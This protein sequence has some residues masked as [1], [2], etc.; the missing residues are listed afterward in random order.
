MWLVPAET[1]ATTRAAT[2]YQPLTDAAAEIAAGNYDRA[3]TLAQPAVARRQRAC[4]LRVLLQGH[5]AA[6]P[7]PRRGCARRRSTP[8]RSASRPAI[9]RSRRRSAKPRRPSRSAITPGAGIYEKLTAD[10]TVVNEQILAK[11]AEAA[12]VLGDRRKTAE[13]LLRIYYE[14]PLTDAAVAA[15]AELEPLRDIIVRQGYKLDL[16]RAVQLYGARRYSD[17]RAAFVA[18]QGEVSGD[19]R[20][21]VD[22]RIAESD[23]FLQRH[24]A[25]LDGL[26]PWLE[27][28]SRQAEARFFHLSALRGLGRDDEFLAQTA[29]ARARL[30]GQLLVRGSAQQSRHLLHPQERR[31]DGGEGLR[32]A[33]REVPQ[34]PARRA[35]GLEVRMVGLQERRVRR[36]RARL[37]GRGR[38]VPAVGLPAALSLL[39]GA[40]ARKARLGRGRRVAAAARRHRLRQFV[41]RPAGRAASVPQRADGAHRRCHS[42]RPTVGCRAARRSAQRERDPTPP[43]ERS[44]RRRAER[45]SLRAAEHA[46]RRRSSRRRSR[47]PITGR[48]SC[49]GPSR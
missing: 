8:S 3:L 32:S 38:S 11:Q 27:R 42:G 7:E 33:L 34:R 22:L 16:G 6:A 44:L 13:A 30:S 19:D 46:D 21:L 4:R 1:A 36:D 17:A 37:R 47:G 43:R 15:G 9:S 5:R 14:F 10:K 23:F 40:F 41:L 18:L 28:G 24:P 29:G 20:E 49:G 48:A 31:R 25:A 12:R 39:V 45:A 26:R 35:R 2:L